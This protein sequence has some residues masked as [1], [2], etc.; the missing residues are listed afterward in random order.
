M[1]YELWGQFLL[2]DAK[3]HYTGIPFGMFRRH[4]AQ[5]TQLSM[6]QTESMLRTAV[7]LLGRAN[8]LPVNAKREIQADL[9]AYWE[10]YPQE[11]WKHS[12]RLA[13][14]GLPRGIVTALREAKVKMERVLT[15]F[16]KPSER[17]K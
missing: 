2:A 3:F 9:L 7:A 10:A 11:L 17:S 13:R 5:K 1:D 6:E 16:S 4:D 15:T 8:C 14:I 12:G